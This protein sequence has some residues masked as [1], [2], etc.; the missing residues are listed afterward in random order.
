MK[1]TTLSLA[2]AAAVSI[3]GSAFAAGHSACGEVSVGAMG[4]ASGETIAALQ[5]FVLEQGYGCE[6]TIVPTDTVPVV[7]SLAE[8]GQPD[9][10][11]ELWSNSVPAFDGLVDEGKVIIAGNTFANGGE[12][13][14]WIPAYVA[15]AHPE[16]TTLEG[17][18]ANPALVD[19]RFHNC[20]VGWG[21]RIVND[22]LKVVHDMEGKGLEVFDHGSGANL[23][24]SIAAAYEDKAPWFGYYWGP[25]AVLGNYPMVKVDL[26]GVDAEQHRLNQQENQDPSKIGVSDFPAA[27]VLTAMTADFAERAPAAADFVRN[28][29][30]PNDLVSAMLAWKEENNA[31]ADETAAWLLTNHTDVVMAMVNDEAKAKLSKLF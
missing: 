5:A 9:I 7:T 13:G 6:V 26:G 17:I 15:E 14:W 25:T 11:P 24:A 2:V 10:V 1:K 30:L 19:G 4:W 3:S 28:S 21:C 12:E 29:A 31:S 27:P 8:T 20:P 22:N 23:A 18:L 16:A